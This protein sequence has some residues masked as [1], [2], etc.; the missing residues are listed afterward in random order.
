MA[1]QKK[2]QADASAEQATEQATQNG[3]P[4]AAAVEEQLRERAEEIGALYDRARRELNEAVQ[5][6]RAEVAQLDLAQTRARAERW[7]D[8]NPTLTLFL[9]IGAGLLAGRLL[10]SA[11][12]PAPPPPLHVRARHR[13]G[14][15]AEQAMGFASGMGAVVASQAA[16]AAHQA[17]DTG[18]RVSHQAA[19]FGEELAR[20]AEAAGAAF[21]ERTDDWTDV[22]SHRASEA[23][24]AASEAARRSA[25]Q[26]H[27]A[28]GDARKHLRKQSKKV[29]RQVHTGLQFADTVA[30]AART[31]VAAVVIKK[32]NDFIKKVS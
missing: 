27:D 28:S 8:E 9:G 22:V 19:I 14:D 26:L 6:L 3:A 11:F 1:E 20:R 23:V 10:S 13:A 29:R 30:A 7:V 18:T 12:R 24:H 2:I 16:R 15:L 32:V 21:S 4:T 25:D 17:R 31:A 5:T